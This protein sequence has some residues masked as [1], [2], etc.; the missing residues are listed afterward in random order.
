MDFVTQASKPPFLPSSSRSFGGRRWD[1]G[2]VLAA[3][4]F[5]ALDGCHFLV[6]TA[7]RVCRDTRTF[8]RG[9]FTSF[10]PTTDAHSQEPW[11][12]QN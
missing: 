7:L 1:E 4:R 9:M 11:S 6:I 2:T 8:P 5:A 12:G 3:G 10:C